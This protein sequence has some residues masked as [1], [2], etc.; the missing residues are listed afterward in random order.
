MKIFSWM[1]EGLTDR[2]VILHFITIWNE[3]QTNGL[4]THQKEIEVA[5]ER[6]F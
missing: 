3:I 6:I 5:I 2:F 1:A 4:F